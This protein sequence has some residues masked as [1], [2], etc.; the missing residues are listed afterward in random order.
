[1]SEPV[2][3]VTMKEVVL[4]LKEWFITEGKAPDLRPRTNRVLVATGAIEDLGVAL[5]AMKAR[6]EKP[7]TA[8]GIEVL[9]L[10]IHGFYCG[11]RDLMRCDRRYYLVAV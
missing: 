2:I 10:T 5:A 3:K 9:T 1:M 8:Q 7:V 6:G 4:L 11:L